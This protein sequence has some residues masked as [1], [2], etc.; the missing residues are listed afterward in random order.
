VKY[1]Q[2]FGFICIFHLVGSAQI[3]TISTKDTTTYSEQ[4]V[5]GE[6]RL[7]NAIS[8]RLTGKSKDAIPILKGLIKENKSESVYYYE[9]ARALFVEKDYDNAQLNA[10][11]ATILDKENLFYPIFEA[12]IYETQKN[13]LMASEIY[14]QIIANHPRV[15]EYYIKLSR[16][17]S[18][19]GMPDKSI[20]TI[21]RMMSQFGESEES[22]FRKFQIQLNAEKT[23]DA[24]STLRHLVTIAPDNLFYKERLAGAYQYMGRKNDALNL[25][26]EILAIDPNNARAN[27]AMTE[28]NSPQ[29]PEG[30]KLTSI[31]GLV[32]SNNV[33]IDQ[34]VNEIIPF[35]DKY[36]Q[37]GDTSL[38]T[39]LNK[40]SEILVSTH[41]NEAKAWALS[42]DIRLHLGNYPQA[43]QAYNHSIELNKTVYSIYDQKLLILNYLKKFDEMKI[44]ANQTLDIFPNKL[45]VYINLA[46]AQI[47]TDE[48]S[49]AL[50]TLQNAELMA[51]DSQ[52]QAAIIAVLFTIAHSI[53][54]NKEESE[55]Y[56]LKAESLST[57][58][59]DLKSQVA[60]LLT[61]FGIKLSFARKIMDQVVIY[62]PNDP[63]VNA[64]V[65]T[66]EFK[67]KNYTS[68]LKWVEEAIKDNGLRYPSIAEL[69][70]DVFFMSKNAVKAL[71]YWNLAKEMGVQDSTLDK[72][73]ATKSYLQ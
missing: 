3:E 16:L 69:A 60:G 2:I 65:A 53:A 56:L 37:L 49:N 52:P 58:N 39:P 67:D 64:T 71:E 73:I 14:E 45:N 55:K 61:E 72:K 59:T 31:I 35:L 47:K 44:F 38:I 7:I 5:K 48:I 27:V 19:A 6:E 11:K 51:S 66:I 36:I 22:L 17:Y 28:L 24:L 12:Q 1:I 40:I 43:L 21:D 18:D 15:E 4:E 8:L 33:S 29:S 68:A 57:N 10:K 34:K 26:K 62:R 20:E 42:G 13:P 23:E 9:L 54:K 46:Y 25:Y 70:G 32:S 63:F 30:L 50:S 41:P